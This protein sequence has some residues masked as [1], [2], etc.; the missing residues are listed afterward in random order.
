[1]KNLKNIFVAGAF[2]FFG[3]LAFG[4]QSVEQEIREAKAPKMLVQNGAKARKPH[5]QCAKPA[6]RTMQRKQI[7]ARP[8]KQQPYRREGVR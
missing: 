8:A 7:P 3:H 4:Q 1:M 6:Q 5:K 2:L